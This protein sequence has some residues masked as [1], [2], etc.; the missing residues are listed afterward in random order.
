MFWNNL[1]LPSSGYMVAECLSQ[2]MLRIYQTAWH[3]RKMTI[4]IWLQKKSGVNARLHQSVT[5]NLGGGEIHPKMKVL[6]CKIIIVNV[7]GIAI[8]PVAM[9]GNRKVSQHKLIS[10]LWHV[11]VQ[12]TSS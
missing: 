5:S 9:K 2:T 7:C 10:L 11:A 6:Q 4:F 8:K 12:H 3:H 1:F